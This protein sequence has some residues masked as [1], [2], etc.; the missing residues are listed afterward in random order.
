MISLYNRGTKKITAVM[1]YVQSTYK[2]Q[3]LVC[4]KICKQ[5]LLFDTVDCDNRQNSHFSHQIY[6]CIDICNSVI[7]LH[8]PCFGQLNR[9]QKSNEPTNRGCQR[10][11]QRWLQIN[12]DLSFLYGILFSWLT[13]RFEGRIEIKRSVE[14]LF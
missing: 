4:N 10:Y 11:N 12:I 6:F 3:R 8:L 14:L 1:A 13:C 9:K 2:E 5:I 7:V